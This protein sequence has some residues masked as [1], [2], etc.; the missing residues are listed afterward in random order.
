MVR[1]AASHEAALRYLQRLDPL[2][3]VEVAGEADT[4]IETKARQVATMTLER[5]LWEVNIQR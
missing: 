4:L 2:Q 1:S 3:F 5:I